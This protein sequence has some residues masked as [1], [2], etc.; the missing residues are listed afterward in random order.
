MAHTTKIREA[1]AK[2]RLAQANLA[3][4]YEELSDMIPENKLAKER[5]RSA[6]QKQAFKS[7]ILST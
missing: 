1:M 4:L 2:I 5:E 7:K 6:K 3:A